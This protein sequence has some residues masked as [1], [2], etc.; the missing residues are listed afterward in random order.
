MLSDDQYD[1][2]VRILFADIEVLVPL[3]FPHGQPVREA[4]IRLMAVTMRRWLVDGDLKKLLA[5]LR[6][7]TLFCVQG[8][9]QAK[10]YVDGSNAFRYYLTAGVM[11]NGQAIR[12]I[13]ES[14]MPQDAVDRSFT[15]EGHVRLPLKKF[16]AQPRLYH[17]GS[18]FST[19]QILRFVANKLGG[20]HLDFER[21]GEWER[22]N[23]ANTFMRYGGPDLTSPPEGSEVYLILE[24][25]SDEVIGGVHL[26]IIAAAAAFVQMEID[27]VQLFTL[28]T[29]QGLLSWLRKFFRRPA[30]FRMI[31]QSDR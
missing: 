26:E 29:E 11:A 19:E 6:Q 8:N 30:Y 5:P 16:L 23:A 3:V 18:W 10:A 7:T 4:H 21:T 27:G 17:C 1:E 2:L 31:E 12:H 24:P 15:S 14:P 22:L 25:S 20:N 9:S 13:Y 28:H